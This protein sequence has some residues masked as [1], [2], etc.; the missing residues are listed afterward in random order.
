MKVV[1]ICPLGPK[2]TPPVHDGKMFIFCQHGY[3]YIPRYVSV[4]FLYQEKQVN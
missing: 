4:F 1:V 2:N 3:E